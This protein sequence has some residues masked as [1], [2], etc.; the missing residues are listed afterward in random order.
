MERWVL[1]TKQWK[2]N[3][4]IKQNNKF[5]NPSVSRK[6]SQPGKN[7]W[8]RKKDIFVME[9]V[10]FKVIS[11]NRNYKRRNWIH[12][13]NE[14]FFALQVLNRVSAP[15][16]E[17]LVEIVWTFSILMKLYTYFSVDFTT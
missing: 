8:S 14:V 4:I 10:N 5:E 16:I 7:Y 13:L 15:V 9:V 6:V 12:I 3:N 2:S 11:F 1:G 17:H